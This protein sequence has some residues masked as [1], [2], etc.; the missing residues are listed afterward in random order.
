MSDALRSV[1]YNINAEL[2][3]QDSKASRF[4]LFERFEF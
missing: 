4:D 3:L 2:A 1:P